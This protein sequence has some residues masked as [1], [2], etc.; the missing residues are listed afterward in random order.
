[1]AARLRRKKFE[2]G[3]LEEVVEKPMTTITIATTM[4]FCSMGDAAAAE[5]EVV[6]EG[7]RKRK[8]VV[9]VIA[10]MRAK[11]ART[12]RR[13][14]RQQQ[15]CSFSRSTMRATTTMSSTIGVRGS[16]CMEMEM[17]SRFYI[18]VLFICNLSILFLLSSC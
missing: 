17:F 16:V 9:V 15:M 1:M 11:G 7:N 18:H 6:E 2:K 8:A 12:R 5:E 14:S 13:L 10:R 3:S 4:T